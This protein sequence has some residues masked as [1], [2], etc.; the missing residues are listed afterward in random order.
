MTGAF[1]FAKTLHE[2]LAE[3]IIINIEGCGVDAPLAYSTKEMSLR[4]AE[5]SA[6]VIDLFQKA[7]NV[8]G[9]KT[10]PISRATTTDGYPFAK[11]GYDVSTV[12][13]FSSKY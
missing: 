2:I 7:A 1:E 11:H 10:F 13:R 6:R 3:S 5:T 9:E 12:W 8:T 4:T